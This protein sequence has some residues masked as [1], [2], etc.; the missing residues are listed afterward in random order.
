MTTRHKQG[1]P[2][3]MTVCMTVWTCMWMS[4]AGSSRLPVSMDGN[5]QICMYVRGHVCNVYYMLTYVC[6]YCM[7]MMCKRAWGTMMY[8]WRA[9]DVCMGDSGCYLRSQPG[10]TASTYSP[11]YVCM[12][13]V[14]VCIRMCM[15]VNVCMYIHVRMYECASLSVQCV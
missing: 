12:Y 7:C 3:C 6:M 4:C 9:G 15:H 10:T 1:G 2:V 8:V 13:H 5:T 14:S 11:T